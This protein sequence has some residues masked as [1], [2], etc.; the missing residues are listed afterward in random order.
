MNYFHA[1]VLGIVEGLTEFLPI[2][3][4]AHLILT[5][6][7]LHLPQ[8]TFQT[9]FEVFIQM[10]AIGA[11]FF[12]YG[13]DMLDIKQT[14]NLMVSFLPTALVGFVLYKIIKTVFFESTYLIA[15]SLIIVG[16]AFLL[17]ES[18]KLKLTKTLSSLTWQSAVFIGLAQSLAVVPGVSRAGIVIATMMLMG[19]TRKEAARYSFMLAVP[20]LI[21]AGLYDLYKMRSMVIFSQE[22]ILLIIVGLV[23]SFVFAYA[24]MR[25]FIAF[26]QRSS[27]RVFGWYRITLGI[28]T[29]AVH[30]MFP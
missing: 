19:Y 15:G 20:T 9:F 12:L 30:L 11:V 16:F 24:T 17:V 14:R 4:T 28:I 22:R 27:L 26:L 5:S 25:W 7:L 13:K 2:S 6:Q 29:S 8:T 23:V 3:S 10:G 18:R 1:T 21:S